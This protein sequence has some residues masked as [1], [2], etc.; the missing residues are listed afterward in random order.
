MT[1]DDTLSVARGSELPPAPA[2]GGTM[3]EWYGWWC[4]RSP[5]ALALVDRDSVW[6]FADLDALAE[7]TADR[8]SVRVHPGDVVAVCL[9][10][11]V[12]LV[13][14]A[15]AIAK[16]G[17]VY[18]PLGSAPGARRLDTALRSLRV[19][20]LIDRPERLSRNRLL[21]PFGDAA[22]ARVTP[23][24]TAVSAPDGTWYAVL[25]SGTTGGPKIVTIG[26]SSLANL[27]RWYSAFVGLRGGERHSLLFNPAFDP[28]LLEL[29]SALGSGAA[30]C[31]APAESAWDP[32]ALVEWWDQ[33]G[34]TVG[35]LPTPLAEAV[36]ERPWPDR[37]RLRHLSIGGDRLRR[38]PAADVTAEVHNMYGPAEATVVTTVCT[39]YTKSSGPAGPPIGRPLPGVTV[40]VTDPAGRLLPRDEP[41]ELVIG[42]PSLT[43]GCVNDDNA[44]ARFASPPAGLTTVDTIY[45]SGDR[46]VMRADGVLEF[47][48][49]LDDQVKVSGA[50]VEPAEVEQALERD[51]QVRR[52]VVV[53]QSTE[54]GWT[55][56][57]AFV[58]PNPGCAPTEA[59]LL[60]GIRAW[61]PEQAIPASLSLVS[62]IPLTA[63]GKIDRAALVAT[64]IRPVEVDIADTTLSE[65]EALVLQLCRRLLDRPQTVLTDRF[66]DVGGNSLRTTRLL[67]SIETA[68]GVRLRAAAVLR[69]PDL[70]GIVALLQA[71][72]VSRE[73]G[74]R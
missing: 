30:L 45:R 10:R 32:Q 52:A 43:L 47:L 58:Q 2:P 33:A 62:A 8:L 26:G 63:N 49:R 25:T 55:Q 60:G 40:G 24:E 54:D 22:A 19:T 44:A 17:A 7:E 48:G 23:P 70:G 27:V 6:T 34:V 37:L 4:A 35:F 61:L 73:A 28:H 29:W 46:V 39:L 5:A 41:G 31:V 64:V 42:G 72:L 16:L 68:T 38:W 9:D 66:V 56:L 1:P 74:G 65:H 57:T 20:C 53:A 3:L 69:Q 36:L 67:A 11:S 51:P 71:E 21:L 13:T 59:R 14:V 15:L 50:R 12:A 18:L